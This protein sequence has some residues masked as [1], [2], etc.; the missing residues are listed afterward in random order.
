MSPKDIFLWLL[1]A[2]AEGNMPQPLRPRS[3]LIGFNKQYD[4][5]TF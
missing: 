4:K 5:D 1:H 3:Y 2:Q